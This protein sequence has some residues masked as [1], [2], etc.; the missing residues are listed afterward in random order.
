MRAGYRERPAVRFRI[1]QLEH[2]AGAGEAEH[3]L[4]G[5]LH[6]RHPEHPRRPRLLV[7]G[8]DRVDD[9]VEALA[10]AEL[11]YGVGVH[12]PTI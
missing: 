7:P 8:A 10:R 11:R 2:H 5:P 1:G 9:V 3:D 12:R 4:P 6:A